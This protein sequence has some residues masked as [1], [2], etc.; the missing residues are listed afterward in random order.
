VPLDLKPD[1]TFCGLFRATHM[2]R[3]MEEY[4]RSHTYT[5]QTLA[6]RI[7]FHTRVKHVKKAENGSGWQVR[8]EGDEKPLLAGKIIDAS[9]ITT[10][11]ELS[12]LPSL[13]AFK[14][15]QL[16]SRELAKTDLHAD[17]SRRVIVIGGGKSAGD[18]A[19]A[20]VSAGKDVVWLIRKSGNGP[21]WYAPVHASAP[22]TSADEPL[23]TRI[24]LNITS[25]HFV[26]ETFIVRLL[27]RTAI[28]RSILRFLWRGIEAD[29][30]KRARY[31]D[32][33][34]AAKA[35]RFHNL[36]PDTPVYW[37]NDNTGVEQREDFF[38]VI[39][40]RVKVYRSDIAEIGAE[41]VVLADGTKVENVDMIIYSTGWRQTPGHYDLQTSAALGLPLPLGPE[42]TLSR[43][44]WADLD[45]QAE[46]SVLARFP[47]LSNPP[48]YFKK[49]ARMTPYRLYRTIVP[50]HDQSIVFLGRFSVVN[51]WRVAEVQSLWAVAALDGKIHEMQAS[52]TGKVP[53]EEKMQRDVAE[54]V[55]WSRRRYLNKGLLANWLLWDCVAYTDTLLADLGLTSHLGQEG[56][57]APCRAKSLRG[58]VGEYRAKHGEK[59]D[60]SSKL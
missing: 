59:F 10:E 57:L 19:Y 13:R 54:M 23:L 49:E 32:R 1:D 28:G 47:I 26:K 43:Q 52:D 58:L 60:G 31:H 40:E 3:Y 37:A 22:F 17:P 27:N 33:P 36:E 8:L 35:N 45:A 48:R 21:C 56:L 12:D 7:R 55:V 42:A 18:A 25:S 2:T 50:V 46:K 51:G 16:H 30:R 4:A 53:A 6:D 44:K 20:A 29:F 41:S 34:G 15:T 39:A 24:F 11:P 5:G 14:G 38:D 9:G